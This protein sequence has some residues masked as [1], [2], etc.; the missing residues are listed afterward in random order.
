MQKAQTVEWG[1][2]IPE[3]QDRIDMIFYKN[4]ALLIEKISIYA[5]EQPLSPI[6]HHQNN[7]FPSDHF[8]LIADLKLAL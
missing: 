3:P 8:A 6:P 1:G 2:T 4:H 5:G 7:D